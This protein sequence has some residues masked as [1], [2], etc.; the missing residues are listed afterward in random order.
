MALMEVP[1]IP[2]GPYSGNNVSVA[3]M[4][5]IAL[6]FNSLQCSRSQGDQSFRTRLYGPLK[7][8]GRKSPVPSCYTLFCPSSCAHL[9][10]GTGK[11]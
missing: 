4:R 7:Q 11:P 8:L 2:Q 1:I 6:D 5:R 10:P 9:P 3:N